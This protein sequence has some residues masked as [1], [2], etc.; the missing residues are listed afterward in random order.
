M[1]TIVSTR[2]DPTKF[3]VKAFSDHTPVV[4]SMKSSLATVSKAKD[5]TKRP[6]VVLG[7]DESKQARESNLVKNV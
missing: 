5:C 3:G 7:S 2:T 1:K 4:R 6:S